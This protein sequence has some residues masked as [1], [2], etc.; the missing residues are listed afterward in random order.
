MESLQ[1]L[2]LFLKCY[3]AV[4]SSINGNEYAKNDTC[5]TWEN[6]HL[7]QSSEIHGYNFTFT[8]L[9]IDSLDDINVNSTAC[10]SKFKNNIGPF[11]VYATR[12][13]FLEN[14]FDYDR[15]I[16]LFNISPSLSWPISIIFQNVRVSIRKQTIQEFSQKTSSP[17]I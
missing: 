6:E 3:F 1:F 4:A 17:L 13:I 2:L 8:F 7:V 12:K 5:V 15:L 9:Q 14:S 16:D 10:Q 11:K